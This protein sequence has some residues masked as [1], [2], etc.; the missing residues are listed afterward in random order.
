MVHELFHTF[1]NEKV[2]SRYMTEAIYVLIKTKRHC[3][4]YGGSAGLRE[5]HQAQKQFQHFNRE[6]QAQIVQDYFTK[7]QQQLETSAY[8]SS[9][10]Q[11]QQNQL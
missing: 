3:Y 5:A 11:I 1:Q 2:G 7:Q 9:L 4:Q 10:Q 8:I 6:Q